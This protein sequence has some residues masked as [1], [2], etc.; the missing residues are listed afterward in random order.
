ML[1][2]V[3]TEPDP[4]RGIYETWAQCKSKVNSVAWAVY[5]KVNEPSFVRIGRI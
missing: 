5:Q 2:Y 4:I 3:I 1:Y